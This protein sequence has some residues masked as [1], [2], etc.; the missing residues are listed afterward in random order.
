MDCVVT[1][2]TIPIAALSNG[3]PLFDCTVVFYTCQTG[4]TTERIRIYPLHTATECYT[5][6][7]GAFTEHK[8]VYCRDAVR[9][10]YAFQTTTFAESIRAYR[11]I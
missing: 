1:G 5:C 2:T 3:V 9:Y 4:A 11:V 6:Q 7:A 8:C 10:F